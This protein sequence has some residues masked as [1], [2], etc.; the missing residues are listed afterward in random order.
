[1]GEDSLLPFVEYDKGVFILCLTSN[2]GSEN[3]QTKDLSDS[4]SKLYVEVAKFASNLNINDNIGL[5]VG[6]T[7]NSKMEELRKYSKKI[8]WL[9]PGVGFQGGSLEDSVRIGSLY[10]SLPIINVSRGIISYGNGTI[11]DISLAC[12]NYTKKI[13][14]I[15]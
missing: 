11:D 3:F 7:K 6:A 9:I 14:N 13:R 1:M 5:V 4:S 8:P 10:N 12:K 15:L 2:K